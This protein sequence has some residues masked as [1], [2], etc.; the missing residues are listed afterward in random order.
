M[1]GN[2]DAMEAAAEMSA[3]AANKQA[4]EFWSE[5]AVKAGSVRCMHRLAA[6]YDDAGRG[7]E[8][9]ALLETAGE[10]GD[11]VA[12]GVLAQLAS[13]V[14][15]DRA[16]RWAALGVPH[17]NAECMRIKGSLI[18][19]RASQEGMSEAFIKQAAIAL[20]WF[21]EA[22]RRGNDKAM[23][24]AGM[25]TEMLGPEG[26]AHYWFTHA[27]NLGNPQARQRLGQAT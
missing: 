15:G 11:P 22:A 25:L 17:G 20:N 6:I 26:Q 13:Q 16:E 24:Q 3:A 7:N 9:V 8:A 10:A 18:L 27:A 21:V 23:V 1:M 14:G 12:L 2:V 19:N 5:N 4:E